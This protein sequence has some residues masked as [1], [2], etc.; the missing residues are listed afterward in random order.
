MLHRAVRPPSVRGHQWLISPC[1]LGTDPTHLAPELFIIHTQTLA[2]TELYLVGGK[3]PVLQDKQ[4]GLLK[5]EVA[6]LAVPVSL[7]F[8]TPL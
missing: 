7:P 2:R 6:V 4:E 1:I 8:F 5:C 3:C